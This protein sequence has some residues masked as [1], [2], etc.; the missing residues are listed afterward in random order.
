MKT[1]SILSFLAFIC[2]SF[3]FNEL[4]TQSK[5]KDD[6]RIFSKHTGAVGYPRQD[7]FLENTST[8]E[9][10]RV[11]VKFTRGNSGFNNSWTER[12]DIEP[13]EIKC[14]GTKFVQGTDPTHVNLRGARYL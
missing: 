6:L 8:T 3:S 5:A 4:S 11:V 9:A 7:W 14:I 2:M 12:F 13:G 1:L 10:I